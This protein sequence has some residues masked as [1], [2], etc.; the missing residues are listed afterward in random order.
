DQWNPEQREYIEA[1]GSDSFE[2]GSVLMVGKKYIL[3]VIICV[4]IFIHI[5]MLFSILIDRHLA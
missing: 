1:D 5:K 2:F 4:S 3:F